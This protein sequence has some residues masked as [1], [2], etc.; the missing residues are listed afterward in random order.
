M[1]SD[2]PWNDE[3]YQ[4]PIEISTGLGDK[5]LGG[6]YRLQF[7]D[8]LKGSKGFKLVSIGPKGTTYICKSEIK[9]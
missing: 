3:E 5:N 1:F 2:A 8:R 7:T 9:D 4:L 6:T